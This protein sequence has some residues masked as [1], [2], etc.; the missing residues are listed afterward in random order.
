MEIKDADN[1]ACIASWATSD[2]E[3]LENYRDLIKHLA[4]WRALLDPQRHA[5]V[6]STG[7]Y[8]DTHVYHG[9]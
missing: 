7:R 3:S 5:I 2:E 8:G 6:R 4:P 9:W 1:H